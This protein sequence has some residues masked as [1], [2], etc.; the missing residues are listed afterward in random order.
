MAIQ[1]VIFDWAGTT[2]DY[3]SRA[4]I[5]AF[6]AAF[7]N[8]GVTIT[9]AEIRRDMG[10]DK[11]QHIRKIMALPAVQRDWQ[12]R[13]HHLPEQTDRDDIYQQ[14]RQ[15]LLSSLPDFA[16]LKPGMTTVID[17]LTAHKI[18]YGTT[19]GYDEAMLSI[20]RPIA[21]SQGYRPTI[22]VTSAQTQGVGRPAAAMLQLA[23]NELAVTDMAKVV[24][25]GDSINDILEGKNAKAIT[26]GV[27][28]GSNL[29]G[30]SLA[31]FTALTPNEKNKLREQVSAQCLA[32]DA[33]Y[34]IQS[35]AELPTL[36][37]K[38]NQTVAR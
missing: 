28:D 31:E 15:I 4:P 5:V 29:M 8:V 21:A 14:F 17:Y 25:V 37:T 7:K 22:N 16:Q 34:V 20:V 38:L 32:A 3:G 12:Q 36:L 9:T 2:I 33:D 26:I 30:L 35:M 6:Q 19:T 27:V 11:A 10:L 1:A 18:P 24:K 23:S 13:F